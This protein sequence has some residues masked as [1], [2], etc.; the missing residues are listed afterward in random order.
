MSDRSFNL[1]ALAAGVFVAF[2]ST[3]QAAAQVDA[4]DEIVVTGSH[5][6]RPEYGSRAPIL[7]VDSVKIALI[8]AELAGDV[9]KE[10]TINSGSGY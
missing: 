3:S 1:I 9:L 4:I 8:G 7:I 2:G 10:L 6:R 5:I